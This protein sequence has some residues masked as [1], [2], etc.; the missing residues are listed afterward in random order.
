MQGSQSNSRLLM[1][2]NQIDNLISGPSFGHNL[3]FNYP[4]GSCEPILN[5]NILKVFQWFKEIFNSMNFDPYNRPLKIRNS[6][7]TPTPKV[8][9]D[10][11]V[12]KFIPSHFLT[13][14]GPEMWLPNSLLACTFTSPCLGRK[15]KVK[16]VTFVII[17]LYATIASM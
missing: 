14:L 9:A 13:L 5:I 11:G 2:R 10:L 16:V 1:V 4:I 7:G 6:I 12:W 8:G 15:P 17:R 3:C